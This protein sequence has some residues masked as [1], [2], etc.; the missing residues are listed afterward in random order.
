[1][2]ISDG[3][4]AFSLILLILI[5]DQI[6]KIMIK[7]NMTIGE[8]IHVFGHWFQI[9]FIEN[10]GMA[11]GFIIPGKLGKPLLTLMRVAVVILICWYLYE[12]VKKK[13]KTGLIICISLIIA[14]AL[15]NIIDSIFYGLIF[16]ESTMVSTATMFPDGGG[17][18]SLLHG[19][20][21]D[22]LYFPILHGT[23]PRWLPW[24]GGENFLFFSPIFNLADASITTGILSI[25]VFQK[26]YFHEN[27]PILQE[28]GEAA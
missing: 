25:L 9:K 17:Y 1:M 21:V 11:F 12:L 8:S 16:T 24:K 27:K 22:M 13:A 10:P 18:A 19:R 23:F 28:E 7:T 26:R 20:V 5:V 15:G 3:V 6:V 14:G 2:K 4:K